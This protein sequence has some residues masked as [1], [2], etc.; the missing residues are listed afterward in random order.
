VQEALQHIHHHQH[1]K[2][3][4]HEREPDQERACGLGADRVLGQIVP[5]DLQDF[6]QEDQSQL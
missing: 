1:R 6:L 5:G 3:D 4:R 2:S